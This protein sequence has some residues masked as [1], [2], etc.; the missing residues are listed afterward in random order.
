MSGR[1]LLGFFQRFLKGCPMTRSLRDA[2]IEAPGHLLAAFL[3]TFHRPTT[4]PTK[5]DVLCD[6]R[7]LRQFPQSCKLLLIH[8]V[9]VTGSNPVA[10]TI[11]RHIF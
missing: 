5:C 7:V 4:Q 10:P 6:Q 9:E 1:Q 3:L 2:T 11:L 8:T